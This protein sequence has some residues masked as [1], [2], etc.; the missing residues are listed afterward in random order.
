MKV[1]CSFRFERVPKSIDLRSKPR[2]HEFAKL[3]IV[4]F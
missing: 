1:V 3:V 4:I 2:A